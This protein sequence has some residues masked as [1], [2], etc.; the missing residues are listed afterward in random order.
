MM[1]F[2][3]KIAWWRQRRRREELREE[4]GSIAEGGRAART[5]FGRSGQAPGATSATDALREERGRCGRG[6]A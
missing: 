5:V 6:A 1:S 3:R 2:F 4:L